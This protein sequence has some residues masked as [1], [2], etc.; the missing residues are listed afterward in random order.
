MKKIG[1]LPR[2]IIGILA[3][4]LVGHLENQFLIRLFET[5]S[6]IFGNFLV[7]VIPLIILGFVAAG[8]ADLGKNAGK[9]LGLT[10]VIAYCSTVISGT[11]AYFVD[12]FV[13][14]K[15]H[16]EDAAEMIKKAEES[17]RSLSPF[18][19]IDMPPIMGVMTALLMA[20]TLG[21][22]AAVIKGDTGCDSRKGEN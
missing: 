22:G 15:M 14:Q 7:F 19:T 8:I 21:I 9:L 11:F 5:I 18:F 4:I 20:F 16:I 10:V 2:L 6:G 3:G 17:A 12:S 1:L 13:F